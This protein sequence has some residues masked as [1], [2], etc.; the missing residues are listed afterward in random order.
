MGKMWTYLLLY[1]DEG[2]LEYAEFENA[3]EMESFIDTK[4]KHEKFETEKAYQIFKELKIE[5]VETA[6]R[7]KVIQ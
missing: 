2:Y 3:E 1:C 4:S 5:A 6:I 7:H